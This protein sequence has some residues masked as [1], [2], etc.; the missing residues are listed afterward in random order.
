MMQARLIIRAWDGRHDRRIGH[1]Q[2]RDGAKPAVLVDRCHRIARR[3]YPGRAED[4]TLWRPLIAVA[5]AW[6]WQ[7]RPWGYPLIGA[8][9]VFGVLESTAVAVEQCS[10]MRPTRPRRRP[11]RRARWSSGRSR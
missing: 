6:L 3:A 5:A 2:V 4:L 8:T 10:V 9:L 11:P 1:A 7:R